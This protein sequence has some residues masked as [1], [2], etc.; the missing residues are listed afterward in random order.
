LALRPG[1]TGFSA[2]AARGTI[3]VPA[4]FAV[5]VARTSAA[6]VKAFSFRF[7]FKVGVT[8]FFRPFL[9]PSGEKVQLQIEVCV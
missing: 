6:A 8:V 9:R 1:A 2:F 5:T 4:A 3:A 7:A